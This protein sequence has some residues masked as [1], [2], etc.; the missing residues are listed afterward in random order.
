MHV[1]LIEEERVLKVFKVCGE[2]MN[3]YNTI[4]N[5]NV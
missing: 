4:D 5:E 1:A 3:I 2:N